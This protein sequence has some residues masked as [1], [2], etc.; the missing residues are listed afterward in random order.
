MGNLIDKF[1]PL[2]PHVPDGLAHR[3]SLE[4]L[5]AQTML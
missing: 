4:L 1:G 5:H 2:I 3:M